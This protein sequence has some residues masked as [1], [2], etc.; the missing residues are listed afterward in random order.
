MDQPEPLPDFTGATYL[1]VLGR[2]H[3]AL[4]PRRY[5][6]VGTFD[7]TS[8]AVA[9][10]ASIAVD[11]GFPF[12]DMATVAGVI[13]KPSLMLFRM[14]SDAFFAAH[15]P[16][17]LLGGPVQFAFLDGMHRCEFLLRDFI[18]TERHC[19]RN[20]VIALHDC[21]P[22]EASIADRAYRSRPSIAPWRSWWWAGDV[23]RTARLLRLVRPDLS[24][25]ILDAP[26]TGLVLV[27]NLDP[28]STVLAHGYDAHLRTMLSWSLDEIGIAQHLADMQVESTEAYATEEQIGTR[29]WL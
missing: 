24:F 15:D 21:L 22:L 1:A 7:G 23:W 13:D 4:Q 10:C 16:A 6:E 3:D 12:A 2:L 17:A 27:T 18:N 29:F 5:L 20:S 9:R 8:L 26:P 19:A 25:T 11:P 14:T 28:G